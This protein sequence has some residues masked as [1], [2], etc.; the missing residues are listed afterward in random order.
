MSKV[1]AGATMSIAGPVGCCLYDLT[2]AWGG[3]HPI[4]VTTSYSYIAASKMT[5]TSSWSPT[6]MSETGWPGTVES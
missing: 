1:I 6:A 4:N 2:N 5:K 3:R